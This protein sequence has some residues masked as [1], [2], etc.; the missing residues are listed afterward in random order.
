MYVCVQNGKPCG[1]CYTGYPDPCITQCSGQ[2][3]GDGWE[4]HGETATS[5]HPAYAAQPTDTTESC[6][7]PGQY[8][9]FFAVCRPLSLQCM[10]MWGSLNFFTM[11]EPL[12]LCADVCDLSLWSLCVKKGLS[13]LKLKDF[14]WPVFYLRISSNLNGLY[15]ERL[16]LFW[17]CLYV[18]LFVLKTMCVWLILFISSVFYDCGLGSAQVVW[19]PVLK[20]LSLLHSVQFRWWWYL[21]AWQKACTYSTLIQ[22]LPQCVGGVEKSPS[23]IFITSREEQETH[24]FVQFSSTE[25]GI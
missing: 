14:C 18:N 7:G 12:P 24:Y 1:V 17:E 15:S 25:D 23:S 8:W 16:S 22:K 5:G 21:S 9:Q 10:V 2:P 13:C 19:V 20:C 4:W 3:V 11:P 6:E